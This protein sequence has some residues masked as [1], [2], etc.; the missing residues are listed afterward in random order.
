MYSHGKI[1]TLF[2]VLLI[3][4]IVTS[5]LAVRGI[6]RLLAYALDYGAPLMYCVILLLVAVPVILICLTI[7]VKVNMDCFVDEVG[8]FPGRIAALEQA[9]ENIQKDKC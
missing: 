1:K 9:L 8:D 6:I 2:N 5:F 4:T 3:V 7:S